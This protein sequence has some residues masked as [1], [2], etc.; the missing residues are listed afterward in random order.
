MALQAKAVEAVRKVAEETAAK[1]AEIEKPASCGE[2]LTSTCEMSTPMAAPPAGFD[3][4]IAHLI[5]IVNGK[6]TPKA[7]MAGD[8][9]S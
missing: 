7:V 5:D 9:G 6:N 8:P 1:Y 2:E 4:K 3:D